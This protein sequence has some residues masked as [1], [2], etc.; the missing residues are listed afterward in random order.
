MT[1]K[2]TGSSRSGRSALARTVHRPD[3]ATHGPPRAGPHQRLSCGAMIATSTAIAS[4]V[5]G[6]ST[7]GDQGRQGRR[8]LGLR[9]HM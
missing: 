1:V 5:S 8:A 9:D 4:P 2:D 3:R 7:C 6:G